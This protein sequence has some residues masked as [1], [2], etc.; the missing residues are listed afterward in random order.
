MADEHRIAIVDD[1][2]SVRDAANL[3]S[4]LASV[5]RRIPIVFVTGYPDPACASR[6]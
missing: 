4:D 5:G 1:D 3:Q 6:R 2:Q